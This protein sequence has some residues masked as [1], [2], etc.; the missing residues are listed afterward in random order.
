MNGEEADK[1]LNQWFSTYGVI[2]SERILGRYNIKLSQSDLV[3]AI[4]S[5][6]SFYHRLLQV[7]LRNV[8]NGIILQQANDYHVY[9]QKLFIDYLL[10]G[11]GAKDADAQGATTREA[12]ENERQQLVALGDE[13]HKIHGKHDYLIASSQSALIRITKTF[14][15]E[16]EQGLTSL[17]YMFKRAG[18]SDLKS[19][20]RKAVSHALIHC[21]V[22]EALAQNDR[23][24][25]VDKMNE[26]LKRDLTDSLKDEM[27]DCLS[28]VLQIE[29]D[30]DTE[31]SDFTDNIQEITRLSNS[32]RNQFFDTILRVIDLLKLLPDYKIDPDQDAINREPLYFDKTIGAL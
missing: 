14:N 8:L 12:L 24:A 10:A 9:V 11:E 3:V 28:N 32:Y 20:L 18:F 15:D 29:Y 22:G 19:H 31:I 17:K 26:L 5:P 2:T 16:L 21:N 1:E 25:F 4:K 27:N 7:P 6:F 23:Y 13:F 30:F